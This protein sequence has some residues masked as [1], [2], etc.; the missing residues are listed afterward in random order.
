MKIV[1]EIPPQQQVK[2]KLW[3]RA[4]GFLGVENVKFLSRYRVDSPQPHARM[5]RVVKT[6]NIIK[7]FNFTVSTNNSDEDVQEK[8]LGVH[9]KDIN[10]IIDKES[11]EFMQIDQLAFV[12]DSGSWSISVKDVT[13]KKKSKY[14]IE[15]YF[16]VQSVEDDYEPPFG[17]NTTRRRSSLLLEKGSQVEEIDF[18]T[19]PY[20]KFIDQEYNFFKNTMK[21]LKEYS[22]QQLSTTSIAI[23]WKI[24]KEGI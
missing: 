23:S 17:E 3:F 18:S 1:D 11:L 5:T 4:V 8:I 6:I 19:E 16:G 9:L 20:S 21:S 10:K 13:K 22:N 12:K 7:S 24:F 2:K 15:K 14:F